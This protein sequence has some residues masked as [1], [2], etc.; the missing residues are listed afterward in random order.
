[1]MMRSQVSEIQIT[2]Q[3]QKTQSVHEVDE[4]REGDQIRDSERVP[5]LEIRQK[6]WVLHL[7]NKTKHNIPPGQNFIEGDLTLNKI[8]V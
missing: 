6:D 2:S 3:Y 4:F 8:R 1:M 5:R 7:K